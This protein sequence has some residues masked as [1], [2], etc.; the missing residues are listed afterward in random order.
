MARGS[1]ARIMH[2]LGPVNLMVCRSQQHDVLREYAIER[3][4]LPMVRPANESHLEPPRLSSLVRFQ[5]L[6]SLQAKSLLEFRYY[7]QMAA[8]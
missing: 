7:Y 3:A 5:C 4:G 8:L 6:S 2:A 1:T